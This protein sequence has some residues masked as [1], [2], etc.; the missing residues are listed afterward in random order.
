MLYYGLQKDNLSSDQ[1]ISRLF[2][3]KCIYLFIYFWL[4]WVFVAALGLS[5]VEASGGY[6]SLQCSGFSLRWLL[7]LGSTGSRARGLQQLWHAGSK[8]QAQQLWHT[9]LVAPPHVGSSQT[10]DRTC[11]PCIGRRILN[12]CA[13]REVQQPAFLNL[14]HH[15]TKL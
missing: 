2:F 9:G 6:S 5:P 1:V 11:V 13:T 3:N 4:L 10:R 8:A 7:L 14:A 12:H 15:Y